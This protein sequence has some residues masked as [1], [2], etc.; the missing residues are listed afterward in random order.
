LTDEPLPATGEALPADP[1]VAPALPGDIVQVIDKT[2][3]WVGMTAIIEQ[4]RAWGFELYLC[5][6]TGLEWRER[7]KREQFAVIGVAIL[8][9]PAIAAARRDAVET[10]RI[11]ADEA[12]G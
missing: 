6:P 1:P 4:T 7:A 5:S 2:H 12:K 10:A 3:G 11:L 9:S 8:V